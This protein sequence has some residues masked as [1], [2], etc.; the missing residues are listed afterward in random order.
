MY[1][2]FLQDLPHPPVCCMQVGTRFLLTIYTV[3]TRFLRLTI[4][5]VGT[6]FLLLNNCTADISHCLAHFKIKVLLLHDHY[7]FS[8]SGQSQHSL[9]AAVWTGLLCLYE[10]CVWLRNIYLDTGNYWTSEPQVWPFL[11]CRIEVMGLT[12]EGKYH[13]HKQA[14]DERLVDSLLCMCRS[15]GLIACEVGDFLSK[16]SHPWGAT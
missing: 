15:V 12:I 8:I 9:S 11:L 16:I 4:C 10:G 6:R 13:L 1:D 2:N 14:H 7:Q 3:G 5:T